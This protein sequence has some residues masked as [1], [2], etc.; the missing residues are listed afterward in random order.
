MAYTG[1]VQ[2]NQLFD[3]AIGAINVQQSVVT[4]FDID[5]FVTTTVQSIAT[6][7]LMFNKASTANSNFT[8]NRPPVSIG[9]VT[10][11]GY[12]G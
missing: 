9:G 11:G 6:S 7:I 3:S 10:V 5:D 8:Q 1:T 2:Q 4:G 12:G